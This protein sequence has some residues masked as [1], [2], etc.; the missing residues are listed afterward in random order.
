MKIFALIAATAMAAGP[1]LADD[2]VKPALGTRT[3]AA[4]TRCS[5]THRQ[6]A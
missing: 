1:A 4:S 3:P 2:A 5:G 6:P